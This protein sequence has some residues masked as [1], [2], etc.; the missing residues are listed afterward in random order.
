VDYINQTTGLNVYEFESQELNE[1]NML[2]F[3]YQ[4]VYKNQ[5]EGV[6]E[7]SGVKLFSGPI[8]ATS[9][10]KAFS[11]FTDILRTPVQPPLQ[12]LVKLL[13]SKGLPANR[14]IAP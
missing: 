3:S 4:D 13:I 2:S 1:V 5:P 6:V 14:V 8:N 10:A 7:L 11:S 12:Q 9:S